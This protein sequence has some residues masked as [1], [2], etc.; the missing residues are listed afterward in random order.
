MLFRSSLV[1]F[2]PLHADD[3]DDSDSKGVIDY[4]DLNNRTIVINDLVYNLAL[5]LKVHEGGALSTDY[6]LREKVA[7]SF[8]IDQDTRNQAVQTITDVWLNR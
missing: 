7:V 5:T 6:A 1:I 4:V 2:T 3:I 8:E